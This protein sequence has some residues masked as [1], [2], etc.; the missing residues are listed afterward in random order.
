MQYLINTKNYKED[1]L[2]EIIKNKI[3]LYGFCVLENVIPKHEINFLRKEIINA[4]IKID[5]N[6]QKIVN[7]KKKYSPNIIYKKK[8]AA[9]RLQKD[10]SRPPKC[11]NDL[12]WMPKYSKMISK[13][14]ILDL[15]KSLLDDH[16]RMSQI[17]PKII[18]PKKQ[19]KK[20]RFIKDLYGLPRLLNGVTNSREWHADWPHDSW[21][22]GCENENENIGS[23]KQPFP[24]ILM[25]L[26]LIW[27]FND[28]EKGSGTFV[29]PKSHKKKKDPRSSNIDL[30]K[31]HKNEIQINAKAGSVLIQDSR[32]W[33]SAPI[34]SKKLRI[35]MVNRWSPWWLSI[36]D[37]AHGSM[38][39][40]VCRPMSLKE[41]NKMPTKLK[42][43]IKHLCA[44]VKENIQTPLL[45]RS[46]KS[47]QLAA[48]WIKTNS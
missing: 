44:D 2:F 28:V 42:P 17:H 7:L 35:S 4:K 29:V 15:I 3:D 30:Y 5:K 46:L 31:P 19:A 45:H 41:Y 25:S 6:V 38:T 37:Y 10:K 9:V 21:A 18:K 14:V 13:S 27:Y 47:S 1:R 26:T 39:N 20:N 36:N 34:N 8:L 43:F 40:V 48:K 11:L 16:V 23:I 22:Y 32:L 33:H 24:N 12:V